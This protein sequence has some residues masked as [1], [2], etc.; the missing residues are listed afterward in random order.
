M[1]VREKLAHLER[2]REE[3][4]RRASHHESGHVWA[5]FLL[6]ARV[7]D[8]SIATYETRSRTRADVAGLDLVDVLTSYAAG[9]ATLAAFGWPDPGRDMAHDELCERAI[10][11]RLARG[12]AQDSEFVDA[13]IEA[14]REQAAVLVGQHREAILSFSQVLL[15]RNRLAGPDLQAAIAAALRLSPSHR[16]AEAAWNAEF[17]SAMV[18]LDREHMRR[19]Q[20]P[21]LGAALHQSSA[22]PGG[23]HCPHPVVHRRP[24]GWGRF[25]QD[26]LAI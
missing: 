24:A 26:E 3:S 12:R 16:A 10:A 19:L 22:S 23:G 13:I 11:R 7:I 6:G 2:A 9:R 5:N 25:L 8:V 18:A 21:L 14:G 17:A 15:A 1:T 4:R 20:Q